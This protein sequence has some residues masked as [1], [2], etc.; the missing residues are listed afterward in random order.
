[1]LMMN[2]RIELSDKVKAVLLI[3]SIGVDE[4][5]KRDILTKVDFNKEPNIVYEST[6]NSHKGHMWGSRSPY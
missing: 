6:K 5:H 4:A 3:K 1:M 2:R